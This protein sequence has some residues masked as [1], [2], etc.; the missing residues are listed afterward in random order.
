MTSEAL[1]GIADQLKITV[2]LSL[3]AVCD[4]LPGVHR[5]SL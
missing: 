5:S 2:S 3:A 4:R 1:K